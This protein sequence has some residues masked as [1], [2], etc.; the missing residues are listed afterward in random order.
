MEESGFLMPDIDIDFADRSKALDIIKHIDARIDTFKK[1]NTGIYCT[2]V[3]Y[4]P[5]NGIST[6]DYKEAEDRG[7]FKIDFLN[8]N[9]YEGVKS[10]THLT[11]LLET[12]PLWD[13]LLDD[14]FIQNLFHVNGHGSILRQ[15][16]PKSIEQLAAV[17]AMIRP[18]KRYLIGKDWTTIMTEVWTKPDNE[19]YF[20][21]KSHATAYAVAVVVQMNL[22]CEGISYGYS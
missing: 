17:L 5:T 15:M 20:F 1:H 6:L 8:V 14:D 10:K 13:L 11:Q 7:Y 16:E 12:E 2:S 9:V 21:K 3:P 18:A 19:E 22:I 4:N